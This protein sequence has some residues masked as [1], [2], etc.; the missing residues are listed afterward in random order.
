MSIHTFPSKIKSWAGESRQTLIIIGIIVLVALGSFYLGYM[1]RAEKVQASPVVINCPAEAYIQEGSLL[2]KPAVS[3]SVPV[4][5]GQG[6]YVAS[7]NGAKY[8][9][10]ECS[11]ANR[12][13]E[14]NKIYFTTPEQAEAAGYELSLVCQ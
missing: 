5:S 13:K 9:P 3:K 10:T 2:G 8:Y 11:G 14:E 12:I 1:A 6:V 4:T 7:R